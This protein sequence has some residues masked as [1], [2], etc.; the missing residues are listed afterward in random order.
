MTLKGTYIQCLVWCLYSSLLAT[1]L[2]ILT[3]CAITILK[4][5]PHLPIRISVRYVLV[6]DTLWKVV[7]R[8]KK[9]E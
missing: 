3:T 4:S 9:Y 7:S 6:S 8:Y 1:N 2:F 5:H